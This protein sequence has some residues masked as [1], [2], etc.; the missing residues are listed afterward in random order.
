MASRKTLT[1]LILTV[2]ISLSLAAGC[3]STSYIDVTYQL[4]APQQDIAPRAVSLQVVDQRPTDA[5]A[6]PHAQKEL[7]HFTGLFSLH[8]ASEGKDPLLIGAFDLT[9]LFREALKQR[10]ASEG[11]TVLDQA[12]AD[13][14]AVE[15]RIKA[16]ILD[17]DGKNWKATL[18][19]EAVTRKAGRVLTNQTVSGEAERLKIVGT[20]DAEK[21]LGDIFSDMVNRL[22][23]ARLFNHPDL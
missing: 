16:F 5:I 15:I 9:A 8:V 6:G 1:P 7:E 23:P 21:L 11:I 19:Y 2:L 20:R 3:A 14:A 10:F 4:P 17:R 13:Q 22:D 12:A 18:A